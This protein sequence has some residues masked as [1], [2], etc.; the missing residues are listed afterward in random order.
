MIQ[1]RRQAGESNGVAQYWVLAI[2]AGWCL[3]VVVIWGLNWSIVKAWESLGMDMVEAGVVIEVVD[4]SDPDPM[5][6]RWDND[7]TD[8]ER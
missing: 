5:L 3:A 7:R 1:D 2:L 4:F 8:P 6:S